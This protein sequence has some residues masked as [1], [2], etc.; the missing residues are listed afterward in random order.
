MRELSHSKFQELAQ[1][2]RVNKWWVKVKVPRV[3]LHSLCTY[4][5][6]EELALSSKP[7]W[8]LSVFPPL[9]QSYPDLH[10]CSWPQRGQHLKLAQRSCAN[11]DHG[12]KGTVEPSA[13]APQA[14][15]KRKGAW[16]L[17]KLCLGSWYVL[18]H[19]QIYPD[20]YPNTSPEPS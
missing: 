19:F 9:V 4:G 11:W 10:P 3:Q 1:G 15:A 6:L 5:I 7:K 8:C 14:L 18:Y 13:S 16:Q 17:P 12:G 20:Y 2:H